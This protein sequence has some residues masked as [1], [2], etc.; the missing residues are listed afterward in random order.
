M[1]WINVKNALPDK[2]GN[3]IAYC[4][5]SKQWGELYYDPSAHQFLGDGDIPITG[6]TFWMNPGVPM[7]E[8]GEENYI[9][10]KVINAV[11]DELYFHQITPATLE[12]FI[13]G[14]RERLKM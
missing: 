11:R 8:T 5:N 2:R 3:V 1:K 13:R 10:D 12:N 9:I 14:V 7:P 4:E 6:V